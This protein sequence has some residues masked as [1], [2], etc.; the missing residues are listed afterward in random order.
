MK[1]YRLFSAFRGFDWVLFVSVIILCFLGLAVIYSVNLS[2][3]DQPLFYFKKQVIAFVLGLFFLFLFSFL[4]YR[5]L[6][7]YSL[8][9]Y[10]IGFLF[11]LGVLIFGK[12]V[13]GTTG[14]FSYGGF[15]FQP[16]EFAKISLVIFLARFF[17][18]HAR[19]LYEFK[20][21]IK[22]SVGVFAFIVLIMLQPDF[23]AAI[24]MFLLWLALL[25]IS[26]IRRR[27]LILIL[28][29]LAVV[30]IFSWFLILKDYQKD[31]ILTFLNPSDDP[32]GRGYNITQS[33]IAVGSG[34]L[35]GRG[36]GFG[37]QSQLRFLPEAHTDF[38]F[39]SLAE[40]LGFLVVFL[41]LLVF[42]LFYF[43]LAKI[44]LAC[45]NDFSLFLVLGILILFSCEILVNIGMNLGLLPV[46]GIALPF[47]SYGGSNLVIK[48][49][50]VGVIQSVRI[51]NS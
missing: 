1:F 21:L 44:A 30:G 17:S 26:G 47:L 4:D 34:G 48:L 49:A 50:A 13:R 8:I 37:S 33:V 35:L 2:F 19:N 12:T 16:I 14:W 31:R 32:L 28:L 45:R 29:F 3:E 9:I 51:R 22:S 5:F 36:L 18:E 39:A 43:R 7:N 38:I 25:L 41:T 40:E 24:I 46:T 6:K 15:S 42:G 10:L 11:L 20:S 27:H 23:G